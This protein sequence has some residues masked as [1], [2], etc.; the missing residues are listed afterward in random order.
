VRAGINR[1]FF[2]YKKIYGEMLDEPITVREANSEDI[3]FLHAMIWEA[4]LASPAQLAHYGLETMQQLEDQYWENWATS[5]SPDPSFVAVDASGHKL[6]AVTVKPND[7]NEPVQGWRIGIGVVDSARGYG[8]GRLLMERA[9]AF[10]R[11]QN[12]QYVSLFVDPTNMPAIRLY[13]RVGFMETGEK[14]GL[15]EMRIQ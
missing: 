11:E 10:A 2:G 15:I 5:T 14:D 3:P 8:I 4:I 9:I 7:T 12:A 13:R 6:G 1:I